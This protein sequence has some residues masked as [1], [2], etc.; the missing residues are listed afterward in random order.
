V[1]AAE[2][3]LD[4]CR[5]HFGLQRLDRAL[6]V[7]GDILAALGPLEQDAQIVELSDQRIA[8]VDLLAQP[9]AALQGL[10]G[11]GLIRPEVRCGDAL[12]YRRQFAGRIS[13]VKDSS[14][15]LWRASPGLRSDE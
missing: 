6:Q 8:Q 9:A 12:F 2:H 15:G 5:F 10:L 13:S 4:F 3:L 11:L 14:A 7:V 1:L